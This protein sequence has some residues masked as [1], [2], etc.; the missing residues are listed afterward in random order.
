MSHILLSWI[1]RTHFSLSDF[2]CKTNSGLPLNRW[3]CFRRRF[4]CEA[5]CCWTFWNQIASEQL[6]SIRAAVVKIP[7]S[8]C[9]SYFWMTGFLLRTFCHFSIC[10]SFSSKFFC[11][12]FVLSSLFLLHVFYVLFLLSDFLTTDFWMKFSPPDFFTDIFFDVPLFVIGVCHVGFYAISI[13]DVRLSAARRFVTVVMSVTFL[14]VE[15]VCNILFFLSVD[16]SC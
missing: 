13:F 1:L 12:I 4:H 3:N 14:L 8:F 2:C 9:L 7:S 5:F 6:F 16:F 15:L 10:H 11:V